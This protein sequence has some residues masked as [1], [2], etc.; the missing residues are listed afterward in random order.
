MRPR[1]VSLHAL[2]SAL[3]AVV[4][5]I[6]T[7]P[8]VMAMP[9]APQ[10]MSMHCTQSAVA[11]CDH[12]KPM[13]EQGSPCKNMQVCMGMLGCF[14]MAAITQESVAPL[15]ASTYVPMPDIGQIPSGLAP[16]P[17]DRPPIA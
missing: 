10:S 7:V 6:A 13:K 9:A 4:F 2:I 15:V 12:M 14:N 8:G 11:H 16:P 5:T 3:V 17:N 1:K